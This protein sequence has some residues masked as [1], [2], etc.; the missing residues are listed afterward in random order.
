MK[1]ELDALQTLI[2]SACLGCD[3]EHMAGD[4]I[5]TNCEINVAHWIIKDFLEKSEHVKD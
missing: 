2:E 1:I 5:M 4:C 3:Y